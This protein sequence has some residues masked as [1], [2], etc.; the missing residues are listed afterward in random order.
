MSESTDHR[1]ASRP[2]LVRL[3]ARR[4]GRSDR[5]LWACEHVLPPNR[6]RWL[7]AGAVHRAVD[8]HADVPED[9]SRRSF[10]YAHAGARVANC[11]IAQGY[12][13]TAGVL[14]VQTAPR[15]FWQLGASAARDSMHCWVAREHHGRVEL[16]ELAAR[17][18]RTLAEDCG[19]A[20]Q[21]RDVPPMIWGWADQVCP[22]YRTRFAV[23]REQTRSLHATLDSSAR[24]TVEEIARAAIETLNPS[25]SPAVEMSAPPAAAWPAPMALLTSN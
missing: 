16:V 5:S 4:D 3:S 17:F 21:R 22:R 25:A 13:P 19:L 14:C 20:W 18:Y 2:R 12:V 23:D 7:I 10:F 15:R 1:P 9:P 11:L 24:R 8:A 6:L